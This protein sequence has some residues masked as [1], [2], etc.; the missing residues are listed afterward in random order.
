MTFN[1]KVK[2][3]RSLPQFKVIPIS[4]VRAVAFAAKETKKVTRDE[5]VL[6]QIS[7]LSQI[8]LTSEDINKI[9]R[10]YPDLKS[11]LA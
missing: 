7:P 8:T 4:E 1:D 6:A 3:L 11:R 10:E 9:L 2:F 5:F